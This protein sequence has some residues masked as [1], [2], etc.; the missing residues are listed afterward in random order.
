MELKHYKTQ[1]A[2]LLMR[3]KYEVLAELHQPLKLPSTSMLSAFSV[4]LR[5]SLLKL[6]LIAI[7]KHINIYAQCFNAAWHS[8]TVWYRIIQLLAT[9]FI[10]RHNTDVNSRQLPQTGFWTHLVMNPLH[11]MKSGHEKSTSQDIYI[12]T[13]RS[14]YPS[15][16]W[17]TVEWSHIFSSRKHLCRI[18]MYKLLKCML[19]WGRKLVLLSYWNTYGIFCF[20][21]P[22]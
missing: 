2:S 4:T 21:W 8:G 20:E 19:S 18:V 7:W 12:V 14:I 5:R 10:V 1:A 16:G 6:L 22:E 11:I 17:G 9:I 15:V 13:W 3:V